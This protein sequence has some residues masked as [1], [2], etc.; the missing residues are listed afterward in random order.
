[1]FFMERLCLIITL[2][3]EKDFLQYLNLSL[4]FKAQIIKQSQIVNLGVML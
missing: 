4:K 1:M 3:E 2:K